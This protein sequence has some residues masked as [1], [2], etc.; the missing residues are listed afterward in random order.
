MERYKLT[1]VFDWVMLDDFY[2]TIVK[3]EQDKCTGI[4]MI[5]KSDCCDC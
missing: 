4:K 1:T 5:F 2:C 3:A